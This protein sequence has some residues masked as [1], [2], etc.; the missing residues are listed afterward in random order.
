MAVCHLLNFYLSV[1]LFLV[2][3]VEL[4]NAAGCVYELH[5]TCIERV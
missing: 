1:L 4:V 3:A 5:L 2:T